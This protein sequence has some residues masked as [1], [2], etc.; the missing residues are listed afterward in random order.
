MLKKKK[1]TVVVVLASAIFV[2]SVAFVIPTAYSR[3]VNIYDK[4]QVLNQIIS[5]VNE[6]YVEPVDWDMALDGAFNGLLDKLD[7]HSAYIPRERLESI[8]EQFHGQFEGIGIE[9]DVLN[10]YLT[11]IAPVAG[12]PSDKAGLQAGDQIVKINGNDAFEITREEVFDKLRGPKGSAVTVTISRTGLDETFDVEIIRDKIPIHSVIATFMLDEETGYIRL[13]RFAANTSDEVHEAIRTLVSQGMRQL[14][15]DLRTNS[16]G[17]LEQAVS[18]ADYFITDSDTLVYTAGRK[19]E[20]TEVYLANPDIGY[21]D[22]SLIVLINRWS[23]SA[24]E[25]VAG[26]VQDLDRGLIVGETSFGKGLVQRQWRLKD[27]SALRVTIARYYT[28]TGRLIQKPYDDGKHE[29]YREL[30][31]EGREE[32]LDSLRT[33]KPSYRTKAGRTVYGGG[34]IT[35]DVYVPLANLTQTTSRIIGH[36]ER[37]TF[38]WGTDYAAQSKDAW[39]SLEEFIGSFEITDELMADFKSFV[40]SEGVEFDEVELDKDIEHLETVM[41][42]EIAGALWGKQAYYHIRVSGDVQVKEATSHFDEAKA[43]LARQ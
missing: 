13:S 9:F 11:V 40:S 30:G 10:G 38:N 4:I 36:P 24:S 17:Y 15:F 22:F 43:F 1:R 5:I 37:F 32:S 28:P 23:A 35:P 34:G 33:N 19:R 26:A 7:P 29:Y 42:A 2:V 6:N 16:G 31:R 41:K 21:G 27:G 8:T 3:A 18:V 39:S 14:I 25:I 12:S 20:T